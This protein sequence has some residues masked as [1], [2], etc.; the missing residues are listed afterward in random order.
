MLINFRFFIIIFALTCLGIIIYFFLNSQLISFLWSSILI[1]IQS[2]QRGFHLK[3]SQSIRDIQTKGIVASIG[4]ISLSFLYG[5]FHAV[6]PGHGKIVISTYLLTQE[7]KL[8]KGIFLSLASSMVQGLTAILLITISVFFLDYTMRE[9]NKFAND[10]ELISFTLIAI[11][12][13]IIAFSRLK[14]IYKSLKI[15]VEKTKIINHNK[16]KKTDHSH[17]H[18][19]THFYDYIDSNKSLLG[20]IISVGIR[21]CS[22]AIIVL[23]LANSI[24]LELAGIFAVLSM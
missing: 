4:L 14:K 15:W 5:I 3:L 20:I 17:N 21:P 13:A 22:G 11:V 1:E 16:H 8:K 2:L 18:S 10:V 12:G 24:N 19:H 6:G 7:S 23:L 9:T